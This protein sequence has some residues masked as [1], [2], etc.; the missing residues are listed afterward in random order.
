MIW[1]TATIEK[2]EFYR[3]NEMHF[4]DFT[5]KQRIKMKSQYFFQ[6]K[7]TPDIKLHD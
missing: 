5:E 6:T 2:I 3:F 4:M 7:S 1:I